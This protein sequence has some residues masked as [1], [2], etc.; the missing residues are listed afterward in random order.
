MEL[1]SLIDVVTYVLIAPAY[2]DDARPQQF[3]TH[4]IAA[5]SWPMAAL[6]RMQ[7]LRFGAEEPLARLTD[8]SF[9]DVEAFL[10]STSSGWKAYP[11]VHSLYM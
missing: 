4:A 5:L 7:R 6:T 1:Q 3:D 10:T 11:L 8:F 2:R 9:T